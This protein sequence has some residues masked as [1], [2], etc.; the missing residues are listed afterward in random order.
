[1]SGLKDWVLE[2]GKLLRNISA[3]LG[4]FAAVV[5]IVG[6]IVSAKSCLTPNGDD[7]GEEVVVDLE[8]VVADMGESMFNPEG[9]SDLPSSEYVCVR[10]N[11]NRSIQMMNW[12]LENQ[13]GTTFDFPRFELVVSGQIRV[14]T[15]GGSDSDSDLY[16]GWDSEVW[17]DDGDVVKISQSNGDTVFERPYRERPEGDGQVCGP[18]KNQ[19]VGILIADFQ[20]EFPSEILTSGTS[21][22]AERVFDDP[23]ICSLFDCL[24]VDYALAGANGGDVGLS[25]DFLG[26]SNLAPRTVLCIE[27]RGQKGGE[28]LEIRVEDTM[29]DTETV[30]APLLTTDWQLIELPIEEFG[31]IDLETV[32][33]LDL[34]FTGPEMSGTAFLQKVF[35]GAEG[36]C[37]DIGVL[38]KGDPLLP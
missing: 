8:D 37:E 9:E 14:N 2:E 24:R 30:E 31:T 28:T 20:T 16:W 22:A 19:S 21:T 10:N 6:G 13:A 1:M 7:G 4:A 27:A 34:F 15:G 3:V 38:L 18:P 29:G 23:E 33:S 5:V 25:L 32:S 26:A 11:T 35:V 36:S 12:Q 17:K